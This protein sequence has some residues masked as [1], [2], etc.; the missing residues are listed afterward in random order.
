M[1]LTLEPPNSIL[2]RALQAHRSGC[3]GC[4][5]LNRGQEPNRCCFF[6]FFLAAPVAYGSFQARGQIGAA[7]AGLGHSHAGSE[8]NLQPTLQLVATLDP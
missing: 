7:A 5:T 8:P 1:S 6:F 2:G 3:S 4:S